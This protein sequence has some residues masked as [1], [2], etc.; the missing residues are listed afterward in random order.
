MGFDFL[1]VFNLMRFSGNKSLY[2]LNLKSCDL[3][4]DFMDSTCDMFYSH[5]LYLLDDSSEKFMVGRCRNFYDH[6]EY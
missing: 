4:K 3:S 1:L 6:N 5:D 2:A